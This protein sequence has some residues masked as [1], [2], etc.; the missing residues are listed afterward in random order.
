MCFKLKLKSVLLRS[1]VWF[2]THVM[3]INTV[4]VRNLEYV[5]VQQQCS[6]DH[7]DQCY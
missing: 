1:T 2:T 3:L 6:C 5:Q 4:S 7:C